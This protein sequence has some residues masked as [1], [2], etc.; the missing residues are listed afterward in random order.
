[1]DDNDETI[2]E[3]DFGNNI[4]FTYYTDDKECPSTYIR[5]KVDKGEGN[6]KLALVLKG[7]YDK[8]R[9]LLPIVIPPYYF[10]CYSMALLYTVL[11]CVNN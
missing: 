3:L 8:H 2:L 5:L 11:V 7:I 4:S 6:G 9:Q 10:C 1:M